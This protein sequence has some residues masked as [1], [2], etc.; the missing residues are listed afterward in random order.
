VT[1]TSVATAT[2]KSVSVKA[3]ASV[4][5]LGPNTHTDAQGSASVKVNVSGIPS[6]RAL[7]YRWSVERTGGRLTA[8]AV[9]TDANVFV[10]GEGGLFSDDSHGVHYYTGHGTIPLDAGN[11]QVSLE[12]GGGAA[13]NGFGVRDAWSKSS[14]RIYEGP[15]PD[16]PPNDPSGRVF[17]GMTQGS[18]NSYASLFPVVGDVGF[19]GPFFVTGSEDES[20]GLNLL[21]VGNSKLTYNVIGNPFTSVVIP[22]DLGG[23]P[24]TLGFGSQS[25]I[26]QPGT[27]F[28]FLPQFPDVT[29][30][31]LEGNGLSE[32]TAVG[33]TFAHEGIADVTLS[34]ETVPEPSSCLLC[35]AAIIATLT[36]RDKQG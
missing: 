34:I 6:N 7:H 21:T 33:F 28:N 32:F 25:G 9:S 17:Y 19:T 10:A 23:A 12:L 8:D 24:L 3:V 36:R 31:S 30:L 2:N 13:L 26:V 1:A 16:A 11:A 18:P 29:S 4:A 5:S 22:G 35:L 14:I 27:T 15:V 20:S